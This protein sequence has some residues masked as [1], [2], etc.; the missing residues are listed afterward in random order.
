MSRRDL[1]LNGVGR[2]LA[3]LIG[4]EPTER[5]GGLALKADLDTAEPLLRAAL[6]AERMRLIKSAAKDPKTE[7]KPELRASNIALARTCRIGLSSRSVLE[8][9]QASLPKPAPRRTKRD[10]L[11]ANRVEKTA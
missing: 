10:R 5:E 1:K 9:L 8:A 11:R 6:Q 2:R 3:D 4:R 7:D